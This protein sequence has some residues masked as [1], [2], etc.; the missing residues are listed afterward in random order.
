VDTD[1]RPYNNQDY[2]AC[3][4]LWAELTEY[5]RAIYDSPEIGG[6]DPGADFDEFVADRSRAGA[7]VAMHGQTIVGLAGLLVDRAEGELEPVVVS[8]ACRGQGVGRRLIETVIGQATKQ[9]L[10]SLK[11]RPVARNADAMRIFRNSGFSTLG[12]VELFMN[13]GES[14]TEW[15]EGIEIHG[16][17]YDY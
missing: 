9:G 17:S 16:E 14:K 6:D 1:I 3:R 4:L 5:H 13:L 2:A 10:R 8:V 11:V 7:W 12:H 15:N